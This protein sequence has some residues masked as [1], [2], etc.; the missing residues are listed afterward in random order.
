MRKLPKFI[1]LVA[2]AGCATSASVGSP[3][4]DASTTYVVR[5]GTDTIAVEQ[6]SRA[7]NRVEATQI[8]REPSTFLAHS[9]V[10]MGANGLMRSWRFEQRLVSGARP[11][12]GAT[13]TW[14]FS[15]D[16]SFSEVVRDTGA[17]LFRRVAGGP[18]VPALA[19]S[20]LTN[21]LAIAYA[22]LQN[23]DSVNVPTMGTGGARGTI[24]IRFV[25]R[26]SVR[27][28][29]FGAPMYAKLDADG[30]IRWLDGAYTANKIMALKTN[31]IDVQASSR[32]YA[33]RDAAGSGLGPASLR[34]TTRTQIAGN[35]MWVDYSR[36]RLS[37]RNVWSNGVLGD[38]LWRTGAN[39][40]T[41]FYTQRDIRMN[42]VTIPAGT[43]TLW[44]RVFPGNSRYEL[45]VNRRI[46]Q[47]GTELPNPAEDLARIPLRERTMPNSAERVTISIE[48]GG[49]GGV[50]AIQWGT[51]RLEAPFTIVR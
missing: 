15:S 12:N 11:A 47:W 21:N 16:S 7:G 26:D 18:A 29:Y 13:V 44:T 46:G 5:R 2:V 35:Q 33:A 48:P 20:M 25:T 23:T 40:A 37:G 49:D 30:Q 31:R 17:A 28:W 41:H 38:T 27:V 50:L 24:P 43:Y 45:I 19:N 32:A 42:G 22:R 1:V 6:Y 51:K 34:D 3:A 14:T 8:Q 39:N 9:N 36:P 10:E 4:P